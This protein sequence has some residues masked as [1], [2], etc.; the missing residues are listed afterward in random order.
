[1]NDILWNS[2]VLGAMQAHA[3]LTQDEL[4]VMKDW[5]LGKEPEETAFRFS[6]SKRT[7]ESIRTRLR[8]K[9]DGIQEYA[10]LPPRVL[11]KKR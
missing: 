10:G 7:V 4:N 2:R 6:M 5:S 11:P 1:M 8:V 9:Y 3:C